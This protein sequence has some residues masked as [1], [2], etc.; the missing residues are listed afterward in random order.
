MDIGSILLILAIFFLTVLFIGKPFLDAQRQA[1]SPAHAGGDQPRSALLAQQES[2]LLALQEL[3]TDYALQK[4][5]EDEYQQQRAELML[6]GAAILKQLDQLTGT[7]QPADR[8]IPDD[9]EALIAAR[10]QAR[11]KGER[12]ACPQCG[13]PVGAGDAFCPSCGKKLTG[14]SS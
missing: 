9:I 11:Q 7:K 4:V 14:R 13:K 10:R 3:E 12:R 1:P 5:P 2:V 6:S 8:Q